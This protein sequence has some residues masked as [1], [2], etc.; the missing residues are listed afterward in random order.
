MDLIV[1][2]PQYA[3]VK[4]NKSLTFLAMSYHNDILGIACGIRNHLLLLTSSFK[5]H[6]SRLFCTFLHTF[7]Y[8]K[9]S[10]TK[11]RFS[12]VYSMFFH[13]FWTF[14]QRLSKSTTTHRRSRH[15]TD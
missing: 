1:N 11:F 4:N 3:E 12:G 13:S 8:S 10:H 9:I 5:E 7:F 2:L 15:S 14:Q 6:L